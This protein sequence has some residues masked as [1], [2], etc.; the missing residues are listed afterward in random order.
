MTMHKTEKLGPSVPNKQEED[1]FV[2]GDPIQILVE[3]AVE[4]W[5]FG[6]LFGRLLSKLAHLIHGIIRQPEHSNIRMSDAMPP[7]LLVEPRFRP[8]LAGVRG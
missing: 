1:G 8:F 7:P 4:S 3:V 5:R 6:R 2:K